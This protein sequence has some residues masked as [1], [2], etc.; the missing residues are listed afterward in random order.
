MS[1]SVIVLGATGLVGRTML[2]ILEERAFPVGELRLL[3]SE[4]GA[5]RTLDFR[6]RGHAVAPVTPGAFEGADLALF[7]CA[8]AVSQRWTPVALAAGVTVV[9]NSSAFRYEDGVPLVVPE[10]NGPLL[11]ARPPLV[12]N[13]NCSTIGIVMALA[14]LARAAGLER[15]VVS[16]YQS[17]SGAGRGALDELERG[18]RAGLD[19]PPP[20]RADGGPPFAFNVVPQIDRFEENG[21]SREEMKVVWESRKILGLPGLPV[22]ATAVRVPVRVGHA[23]AVNVTL[24]RALEPDQARALWASAPGLVVVD[25]PARG[26]YPTPLAA[27]GR[28]EVLVGRA[29]RDLSQPRGLEFFIASDN[30]R[31]GAATNAVQIAEGLIQA[32]R[33]LKPAGTR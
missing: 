11:A 1:L 10:V 2:R 20:G 27:E 33:G 23:A 19:G 21:Y 9:D 25:D 6:G 4:R 31:K 16:T 12:A 29:R 28:D 32:P 22:T 17:V 3:A 30:L 8:N 26:G 5:S 7:A 15:V 13:P 18:V 14:P 24:T